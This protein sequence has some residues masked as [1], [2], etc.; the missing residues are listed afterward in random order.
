[1]NK[2]IIRAILAITITFGAA[3]YAPA[4]QPHG[5]LVAN[6]TVHDQATY[7]K[8][9]EAAGI[10]ASKYNGKVIIYDVNTRTLEGDPKTVISIAEFPTVADAERFY[11][12]P[13]YTAARKFRI[14]STEGSVLLAESALP[15]A[16]TEG[17]TKPRGYMIANYNINNKDIFQK[18]MDAAGTLAPKYNGAVTLFDFNART[19]EGDPGSVIGVAEFPSI[20]DA[21]RFYSSPEYT[22][23][24]K[25]RIASTE[26]SVLLAESAAYSK[27]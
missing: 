11:S 5:Y 1:M 10:L 24:R 15:P 20:T 23:A 26:G 6:Y 4:L 18:Y 21:E 27:Q 13:E 22:A 14:A 17:A 12:S 8:Y 9:M 3:S 19:L 25:F 7:Q 16:I 2:I